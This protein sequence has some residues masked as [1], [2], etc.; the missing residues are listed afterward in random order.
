MRSL[1]FAGQFLFARRNYPGKVD[2]MEGSTQALRGQRVYQKRWKAIF[3]LLKNVKNLFGHWFGELTFY[4]MGYINMLVALTCERTQQPSI[5]KTNLLFSLIICLAGTPVLCQTG[6][7]H[8]TSFPTLS[9][10]AAYIVFGA[11]GD[12]W[13]VAAEGGTAMRLTAMEGIESR[14][15]IS[16]DGQ[17]LTFSSNLYGNDD[18]FLMPVQGGAIRRLTYH[19]GFDHVDSWSWDSQYIYF[20]SNRYNSFSGYRMHIDGTTPERVFDE[21]YFNNSHQLVAHPVT[22]AVFFNESMESKYFA[23]R[24]GYK[25]PYNPDIKSFDLQTKQFEQHTDWQGKDFWPTIDREG[26]VYFISD[27]KNGHYNLCALKEQVVHLTAFDAPVKRPQV[28]AD[29]S[30]IVFEMGYQVHVYE[31]ATGKV[32]QPEIAFHPYDVLTPPIIKKVDGEV[33]AFDVSPDGEKLAFV[34][35][36]EL[37]VSDVSGKLVRQLMTPLG[38]RVV[39]VLWLNDSKVLYN[40]TVGGHLNLFQMDLQGKEQALTSEEKDNRKLSLDTARESVLYISGT[41]QLK[42]LTVASGESRVLVEDEFWGFYNAAPSYAPN[43]TDFVLYTAVRNLERDVFIYNKKTKQSTNMT[44]SGVGEVLPVFNAS[45]R[46]V[47]YSS[48]RMRPSFPRGPRDNHIYE[49]PLARFLAPFKSD[50]LEELLGLKDKDD[51]EDTAELFVMDTLD[52]LSRVQPIGPRSGRQSYPMALEDSGEDI[53]LYTSNHDAHKWTIWMTRKK[54]YGGSDTKMISGTSG[55]SRYRLKST[56]SKHYLLFDGAIHTLDVSSA[57]AEKVKIDH[58]YQVELRKEFEQMFYETWSNVME[59]YYD[60]GH[61][62]K[63]DSLRNAYEGYLPYV[64]NRND[65]RVLINDMLGALNTS[66]MGFVSNGDEEETAQSSHS[67]ATGVLFQKDR[68]YVVESVVHNSAADQQEIDLR[69][70]DELIAVNGEVVDVSKNRELYFSFPYLKE[71]LKLTF[72]RGETTNFTVKVHPDDFWTLR[73]LMYAEWQRGNEKIV[74]SESGGRIAYVHMKNMTGSSYDEF[75]YKM[76][77]V[78]YQKEGLILDLRYN[79]GGNV[80]DDVLRFLSQR[81]YFQWRYRGGQMASQPSFIP[82]SKPIVLLT[83]E[84]TL[85]DGE[86]TAEG[87]QTLGLGKVVG[88]PTYRWIV[89]TTSGQLVDGSRYRLPTWGCYT[90]EGEDLEKIGVAPD[91]RV[92][93]NFADRYEGRFPQLERAVNEILEE[94]GG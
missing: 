65:L 3:S 4:K 77:S 15:K 76:T 90:L 16:P 31:V 10:N 64:S 91:I 83:N 93:E 61:E 94:L 40:Q 12:L 34:S 70:G 42:E 22:G 57:K 75:I 51:T 17:W 67:L 72:K 9:P 79:T 82:G 35:G 81:Q 49:L 56:G 55:A 52:M 41:D 8:F 5:M 74:A 71:E 27:Q 85:S 20:T 58:T 60:E 63:V 68:P 87:F 2:V 29:G 78:D 86:V 73:D 25:G 38:G 80:H 92:E 18:I 13:K 28:S 46:A 14:P 44:R 62:L 30:K 7:A 43:S 26:N 66:H 45:G 88:M 21:G 6:N 89:F 54:R 84:Q 53:V 1:V 19:E 59:N 33:S 23:H 48:D 11:Q 50:E 69:K 24:L 39:E 32:V 47:Y 37:F 36:G